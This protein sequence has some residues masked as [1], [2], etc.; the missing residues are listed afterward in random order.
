M[1]NE[2]I[3]KVHDKITDIYNQTEELRKIINKLKENPFNNIK[4]DLEIVEY[5]IKED[6]FTIAELIG[7]TTKLKNEGLK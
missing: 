5:I 4:D 3:D 7:K 2:F 6:I 1:I